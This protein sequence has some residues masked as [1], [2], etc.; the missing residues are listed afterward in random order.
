[1]Q[2]RR[3]RVLITGRVQGVFFRAYTRDAARRAGVTGWV[4]NLADGRVEALFEG[5]ADKVEQIIE[6]CRKGSFLGRVEHV[7]VLD[8]AYR[9]EFE[10]FDIQYG[11]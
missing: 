8:E 10:N 11:R 5:D 2:Q 7:E 6:W 4:R 3:V 9:G 1:M